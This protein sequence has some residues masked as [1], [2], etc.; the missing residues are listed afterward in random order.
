MAWQSQLHGVRWHG[1]LR[2]LL[3][4]EAAAYSSAALLARILAGA[5][6][7]DA[8]ESIEWGRHPWPGKASSVV[9]AG[10]AC[11]AAFW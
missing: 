3:N 2:G 8:S 4:G 6:L 9:S 5:S 1:L 10:M 7:M 11:S